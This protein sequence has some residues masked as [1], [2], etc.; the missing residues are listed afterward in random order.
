MVAHSRW[1]FPIPSILY[2]MKLFAT[3]AA[4]LALVAPVFSYTRTYTVSY[5]TIYDHGRSSLS[6]VACSNG[7]HG[8]LTA[9]Y[10]TFDSLPTFPYI[11]G[12]PQI[13]SWNSPYC[14]TCWKLTYTDAQGFSTSLNITAIDTGDQSHE[15]FN[16]SL[17]GMNVLTNGH[18]ESLGRAT[19]TV[20]RIPKSACGL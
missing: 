20:A 7:E 16:I 5:D 19:V 2:T 18:A 9:G 12:A 6:N 14:G 10:T 17:E 1:L 13:L 3:V 15:G 8:L 4:V 11:G